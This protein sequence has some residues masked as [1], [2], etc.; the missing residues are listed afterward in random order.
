MDT[1]TNGTKANGQSKVEAPT[2]API[3]VEDGTIS[4]AEKDKRIV[5]SAAHVGAATYAMAKSMRR[6]VPLTEDQ[7]AKNA[8][9]AATR[10]IW[11]DI[12][13]AK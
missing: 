13:K 7:A 11:E 6:T 4:Q 5:E 12:R 3:K 10:A 9:K 8:L 2:E 1:T